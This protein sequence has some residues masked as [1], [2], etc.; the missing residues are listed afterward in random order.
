MVYGIVKQCG[1]FVDIDSELNRGTAFHVYL[2]VAVAKE[3]AAEVTVDSLA[4]NAGT[5][6]VLLA[7]D[8]PTVRTAVKDILERAGYTVIAPATSLDA[9]QVSKTTDRHIDLLLTDLVMPGISGRM[10]A[11]EFSRLRPL[12]AVLFMSGYTDDTTLQHEIR[13]QRLPL[14][15][16]PFTPAGLLTKIRG[17][18]AQ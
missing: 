12:A 16:K 4:P 17:T 7:E 11:D 6:T 8:S 14:L 3:S 18:L 13:A 10:L 1:G 5:E 9:L 15:Q 2:P